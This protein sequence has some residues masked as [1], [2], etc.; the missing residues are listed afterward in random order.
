MR[1]G[2]REQ[3]ILLSIPAKKIAPNARF[4]PIQANIRA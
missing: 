3:D 2:D 1:P 4:N